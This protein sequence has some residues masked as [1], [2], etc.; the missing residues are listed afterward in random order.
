MQERQAVKGSGPYERE[1]MSEEGV[2]AVHTTIVLLIAFDAHID[3]LR[4]SFHRF[5][6]SPSWPCLVFRNSL[7]KGHG[8][9]VAR[10]VGRQS[11]CCVDQ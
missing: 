7:G 10:W 2:D 3:V 5:A 11:G 8:S 4:F 1:R 6:V 9:S